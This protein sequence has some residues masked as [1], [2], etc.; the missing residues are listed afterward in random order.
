[1]QQQQQQLSWVPG[2][3]GK[4]VLLVWQPLEAIMGRPRE[5]DGPVPHGASCRARSRLRCAS[6]PL[7]KR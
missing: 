1:M 7:A 6:P 4:P 5:L 3:W 2:F